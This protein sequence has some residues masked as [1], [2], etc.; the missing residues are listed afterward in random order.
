MRPLAVG[1]VA[2]VEPRDHRI[3]RPVRKGVAPHADRDERAVRRLRAGGRGGSVRRKGQQ[4]RLGAREVDAVEVVLD[5]VPRKPV[6]GNAEQQRRR[7]VG[8]GHRAV[9]TEQQN[10]LV[11]HAEHNVVDRHVSPFA[12][13][14]APG[15]P[16][17]EKGPL[18]ALDNAWCRRRDLNPQD[19][20]VVTSTSS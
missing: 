8:V 17:Y 10:G 12:R 4:A 5:V 19:R 20:K 15:V 6:G 1:L 3:G 9:F 16:R 7:I 11:E 13:G 14:R 2:L 18:R